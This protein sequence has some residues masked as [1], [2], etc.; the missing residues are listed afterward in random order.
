MLVVLGAV[1]AVVPP[2][3]ADVVGEVVAELGD[4][5]VPGRPE[6]G[7]LRERVVEVEDDGLDHQSILADR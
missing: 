4:E 3:L 7:R 6:A 1:D 2:A 5:L